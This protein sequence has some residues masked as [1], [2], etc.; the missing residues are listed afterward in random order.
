MKCYQSNVNMIFSL[1]VHLLFK[2]RI[3]TN[4]IER[5]TNRIQKAFL[6]GVSRVRENQQRHHEGNAGLH[7]PEE[8][9]R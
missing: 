6:Q 4:N 1:S 8:Q 2:Q 5:S 9:T 3:S 7:R